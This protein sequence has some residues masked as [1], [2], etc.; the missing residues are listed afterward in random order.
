[1]IGNYIGSARSVLNAGEYRALYLAH[2]SL[3]IQ[4]SGAR[5]LAGLIPP[6]WEPFRREYMGEVQ[7]HAAEFI[8]RV[9]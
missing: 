9:A 8:T 4:L 3:P 2:G 1:M 6:E 5:K 7:K